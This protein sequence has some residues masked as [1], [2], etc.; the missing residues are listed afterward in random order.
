MYI[1]VFTQCHVDFII[2]NSKCI[3]YL[4]VSTTAPQSL[5]IKIMNF[6]Q[7]PN[8]VKFESACLPFK[9]PVGENSPLEYLYLVYFTKF[10]NAYIHGC[11]HHL[12][13]CTFC[14]EDTLVVFFSSTVIRE[15]ILYVNVL[16]V[17]RQLC[18]FFY[19]NL[20]SLFGKSI[21]VNFRF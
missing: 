17:Q 6:V 7:F 3:L 9:I 4:C 12:C 14:E 18:K 20:D 16:L 13:R 1:R 8:K 5:N 21:K 10:L 2:F 19:G 15:Y 11:T